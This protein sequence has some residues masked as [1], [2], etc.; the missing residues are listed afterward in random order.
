MQGVHCTPTYLDKSAFFD[1]HLKSMGLRY[2]VKYFLL[3]CEPLRPAPASL[4]VPFPGRCL[5]IFR[6]VP[7]ASPRDQ[8]IEGYKIDAHWKRGS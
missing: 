8:D 2:F 4:G 7:S 6:G 1:F 3:L 5:E